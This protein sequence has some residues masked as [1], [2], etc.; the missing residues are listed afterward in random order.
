MTRGFTI[1]CDL[2]LSNNLEI[3]WLGNRFHMTEH[4]DTVV[5]S[6]DPLIIQD[7]PPAPVDTIVGVGAGRYNNVDGF[8]IEFTLVDHGEP[9]RDD[10]ARF[11]VYETAAPANVVLDVPLQ[12]LTGGNIQAHFDQPHK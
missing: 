6:D 10:Q 3:N 9:G 4:L 8:T 1:H 11:L 5:C 7:P 2:L 12:N